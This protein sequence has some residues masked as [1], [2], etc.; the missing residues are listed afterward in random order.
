[1]SRKYLFGPTTEKW[2]EANLR[3]QIESGACRIFG[4]NEDAPLTVGEADSWTQVCERLGPDWQ[5]DFLVLELAYS[6]IPECLWSAPVPIVALAPDWN[7]LWH[8]YRHC[9]PLCD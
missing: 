2:T 1:M 8:T 3:Q 6:T 9:L 4:S 5:P 7:L